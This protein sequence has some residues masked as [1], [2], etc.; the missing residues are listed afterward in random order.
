M[1]KK[2]LLE[3]FCEHYKDVVPAA[4]LKVERAFFLRESSCHPAFNNVYVRVYLYGFIGQIKILFL[5]NLAASQRMC[6]TLSVCP[7]I[8]FTFFFFVCPW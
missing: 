2:A 8:T 7:F 6:R 3:A 5:K 4:L 1:K